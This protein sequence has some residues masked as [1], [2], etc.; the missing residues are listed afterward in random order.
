MK[1]I[2]LTACLWI[3]A[4]MASAQ[5][6]EIE[7]LYDKPD[8]TA[9]TIF[10]FSQN[11]KASEVNGKTFQLWHPYSQS[12]VV[13]DG[14]FG[15]KVPIYFFMLTQDFTFK[16]GK[17]YDEGKA[18]LYVP[19]TLHVYELTE[20]KVEVIEKKIGGKF[21]FGD[22]TGDEDSSYIVWK[23]DSFEIT[24]RE[25]TTSGKVDTYITFHCTTY[26]KKYYID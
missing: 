13:L 11:H 24:A 26:P 23:K 1:R 20:Q 21:T 8:T 2:I 19:I 12:D 9:E 10:Q 6:E 4:I 16:N 22:M 17:V 15:Y 5:V 14:Q 7:H 18:L 3:V 25:D